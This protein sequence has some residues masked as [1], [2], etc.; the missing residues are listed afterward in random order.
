VN[1]FK[2]HAP[3]VCNPLQCVF[4]FSPG[5]VV[6]T[7][8]VVQGLEVITNL[9]MREPAFEEVA[10]VQNDNQF[11]HIETAIA[12]NIEGTAMNIPS[13]LEAAWYL[14]FLLPVAHFAGD[15]LQ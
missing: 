2:A 7:F 3:H 1:G 11:L 5:Y 15:P 9:A 10:T 4:E 6:A 14:P 8:T 12:I 13:V